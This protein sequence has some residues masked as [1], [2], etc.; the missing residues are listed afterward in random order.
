MIARDIAAIILLSGHYLIMITLG[1]YGIHRL[2][3]T[4]RQWRQWRTQPQSAAKTG[5]SAPAPARFDALPMVTVQLP[6]FNERLVIERLIDA[7]AAFDYPR[8]RLEIQILDDS[9]D[10]TRMIAAARIAYHQS[11]GVNIQHVRRPDRS[12]YKAGALAY[13]LDRASGEF[14]LI[15]DAD[16]VP[17]P[18]FLRS[19]IDPLA[20][21]NVAMV[22]ARWD[23]LNDGSSLLTRAQAILLDAHFVIEHSQRASRGLFFNFNGTAGI[24]RKKAIVEAGGWRADTLTEDLD[25]SY[26]AQLAGWRFVYLDDVVCRSELPA[27]MNAFKTQQHRWTK[28]SIEVMIRLLPMIWRAKQP[29]RVKLEATMHLTSNLSYLFIIALCLLL[30]VPGV[31]VREL[32]QLDALL[33]VD[34]PLFITASVSHVSFFIFGQRCLRGKKSVK[35]HEIAIL[36]PMLIGLAINNGRAVVE[37][38]LGMRSGFIRTP[39]EGSPE[40]LGAG[41]MSVY[42]A[43]RSRVGEYGEI[44]L[45]LAYCVCAL[46]FISEQFWLSAPF[47]I[48][49]AVSFLTIGIGSI[50]ARVPAPRQLVPA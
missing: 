2:H 7:A 29:L 9:T 43:A 19:L 18:D 32:Y 13:G 8:D 3:M 41:H 17:T 24:W 23:Y 22:Q 40:T 36:I 10:E 47:A 27:D 6:V 14:L 20:D 16:F 4:W 26:R 42:R 44:A 15:L 1:I 11:L 50:R 34:A 49:Y 37:A 38:L 35:F 46:W 28:G 39:K 33:W 30:F 21:P 12:G 45:G 48:L 25:L 5:A 31:I